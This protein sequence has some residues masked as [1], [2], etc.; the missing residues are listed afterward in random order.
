MMK[1]ILFGLTVLCC[2]TVALVCAGSNRS[3]LEFL[4]QNKK[5]EGIIELPSGLQYRILRNGTG[6]VHP[7]EDTP[8]SCHY[9]GELL[10][11]TEIVS[12]YKEREKPFMF[13]PRDVLK[14]WTEA[15]QLMVQGDKWELYLPSELAYGDEGNPPKIP[16]GEALVFRLEMLEVH[17]D[18]VEQEL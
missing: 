8:C 6:T 18:Y 16:G 4:Q 11:G 10:D 12:S 15:M 7:D 13:A 3:S 14:G 5:N 9:E 17:D 1:S 2:W